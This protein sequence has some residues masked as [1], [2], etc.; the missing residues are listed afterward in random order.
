MTKTRKTRGATSRK[1][2]RVADLSGFPNCAA[3]YEYARQV[4]D[5]S[6]VACKLVQSACH[7]FLDDLDAS[8]AP[9]YPFQFDPPVAERALRAIQQF[10]H[11]E[12]ELRGEML[13]LEPWQQFILMNVFGWLKR[14]TRTRRFRQVY[15]EVPRGN[16]KTAVAA[17]IALYTGFVEG[18]GGAKNYSAA[19]TRDQARL[20]FDVACSMATM[21]PSFL[22]NFGVAVQAHNINQP[23]TDS[24]FEPLSSDDKTLDGK[25][26]HCTVID[27]VHAHK[28][29]A[30]VE[31][32]RTGSAKRKQSLIVYI[33]TA[34]FDLTG[35]GHELHEYTEKQLTHSTPFDD[36]WFG[37]IY[38]IDEGDEWDDLEVIKKA[39]PNFGVSVDVDQ[40]KS[41]LAQ[42]KA[43]PSQRN[44][45]LT[46]HLDVWVQTEEQWT[47]IDAWNSTVVEGDFLTT[48]NGRECFIG[49]DLASRIDIAAM[50]L[51]FPLEGRS[52]STSAQYFLTQFLY[53]PQDAVY[54]SNNAYY[55]GWVE[56]GELI[57]TPG[58]T[59][60]FGR[61]EADLLEVTKRFSVREVAYD[62]W[63]M[64]QFSQRM[65]SL[66]LPMI[67]YPA[68][69]G[70]MSEPMKHL[71]ALIRNGCVRHD[72]NGC[73]TWQIG[74]VVCHE[75]VKG[76]VY[77]RKSSKANKIDGA[78]AAIMALGRVM[79][80][81]EGDGPG[82]YDSDAVWGVYGL[83]SAAEG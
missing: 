26:I 4:T 52:T 10:P 79:N 18:E 73:M 1:R 38:T 77:P 31:V 34:G 60:D 80:F 17:P 35:I 28:S 55:P 25:N 71:D 19:T 53:L 44:A 54:A 3:G 40:I 59:I 76:N 41:T 56:T 69:V 23:G 83:D 5:G 13:R 68:N 12:G 24:K 6:I 81:E 66:G 22:S 14:T 21:S 27:E 43:V 78:V 70:T 2:S 49:L 62:P 8:V 48:L 39:N 11:I 50:V 15:I 36:S 61:I 64:T 63:Q 74:N 16:G 75:D 67:E 65:M 7:R 46:K 9:G 29:R 82:L 51:L 57:V 20:V 58:N 72:D 33:T 47:D 32:I 37:I 42:A 45:F 30:V